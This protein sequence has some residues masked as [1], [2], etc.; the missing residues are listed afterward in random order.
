MTQHTPGPWA[1]YLEHETELGYPIAGP[2]EGEAFI[3]YINDQCER[4]EDC[5]ANARLITA[6]PEM[7]VTLKTAALDI[8][9]W[10]DPNGEFDV[11]EPGLR[12][13]QMSLNIAIA[14]ATQQHN[15]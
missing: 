13:L 14:K 11:S 6:A 7:L 12:N 2:N 4:A 3:A 8:E 10:L 1:A 15:T 9:D 5:E